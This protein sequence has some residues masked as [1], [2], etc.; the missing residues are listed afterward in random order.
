MAVNF[1]SRKNKFRKK[2]KHSNIEIWVLSYYCLSAIWSANFC[3]LFNKLASKDTYIGNYIQIID[4]YI[5]ASRCKSSKNISDF[6][7]KLSKMT[8][9]CNWQTIRDGKSTSTKKTLQRWQ[10]ILSHVLYKCPDCMQ[11]NSL[12]I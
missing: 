1:S 12:T 9:H 3:L 2:G 7:L 10:Y 6:S 4:N 8:A 5:A 11:K